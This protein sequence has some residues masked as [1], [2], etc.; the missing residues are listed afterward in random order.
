MRRLFVGGM[1]LGPVALAGACGLDEAG[2]LGD[3]SPDVLAIEAGSDVTVVDAPSDV[4]AD[5]PNDQVGD[6]PV[7]A[8]SDVDAQAAC[9]AVC[10]AP[11]SC[12]NGVC[13]YDCSTSYSCLN[14]NITCPNGVPCAVIC[15]QGSCTGTINCGQAS[16]C[17]V[18]CHGPYACTKNITCAGSACTVQCGQGSCIGDIACNSTGSC[19]IDCGV[20][21]GANYACAGKTSCGGQNCWIGCTQG[22]CGDAVNCAASSHCAIDC[23][24]ANSCAK[25]VQ[26]SG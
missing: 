5:V 3:A 11:A 9:E 8:G 6:A 19:V 22:S 16:T 14:T 21:A 24:G 12:S 26:C 25:T 18:D 23:A 2:L 15:G 10:Q 7:D 13:T 17:D 4:V 20:D 1:V